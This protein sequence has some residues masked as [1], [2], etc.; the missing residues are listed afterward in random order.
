MKSDD[1]N[2]FDARAK[3]Y[4]RY[5]LDELK[6]KPSGLAKMAG[7]ATTTLT[8]A[9]NDPTHKYTLSMST[10]AKI[11]K[12]SGVNFNPFFETNDF[13]A[14]SMIPYASRDLLDESWGENA[15]EVS[16]DVE[17][18]GDTTL[19]IGEASVGI[20]IE[21]R[22]GKLEELGTLWVSIPKTTGL[23]AFALKMADESA[24]PFIHKGEYALCRRRRP[25]DTLRHGDLVVVERWN[26]FPRMMELSVRRLV[27]IEGEDPYLRADNQAD[28]YSYRVFPRPD[29]H[30]TDAVKIVGIVTLAVRHV[31][32]EKMNDELNEMI[33]RRR[34]EQT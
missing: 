2:F 20:W 25:S 22:I 5:V 34:R 27:H 15:N 28:R 19:V 3:T 31:W 23:E 26:S 30:D 13:P 18:D 16:R 12:A 21:E 14:L 6:L 29:L 8:R 9:L 10:L 4:V 11:Y 33:W 32:D 24:E 7:L 17:N 1:P